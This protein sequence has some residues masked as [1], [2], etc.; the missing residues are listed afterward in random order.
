[1]ATTLQV[2]RA[3]RPDGN[4]GSAERW[5]IMAW[6]GGGVAVTA[7]VGCEHGEQDKAELSER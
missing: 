4:T 2:K 7:V 3:A 6:R 1:M 5:C